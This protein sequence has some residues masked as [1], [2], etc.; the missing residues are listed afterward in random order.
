MRAILSRTQ[1]RS[2]LVKR[3]PQSHKGSFG[4]VLIIA[5][6]RGM[7]GAGVLSA[8]GALRGGAG[9]V[10][11]ATP[12]SLQ[13][14]AARH[15]R[16]EAMTLGLPERS[17]TL[18]PKAAAPLLAFIRRRRVTSIALGPGL[19]R[20]RQA[21][22][23]AVRFFSLLKKEAGVNGLVLD[24]DGFLA[25]SGRPGP[26]KG[27]PPVIVTPHPGELAA[28]LKTARSRVEAAR[29]ETAEKFAK[30]NGVITVLKGHRTVVTDG[31]R[32]FINPTGNPGMA[33]G[34]SGD[35]L[36]GLIPALLLNVKL[37]DQ[38]LK[39]AA[40]GVFVH[41]LAGDLAAKEKT[42][43]AMTAGDIAEKIPAAFKKAL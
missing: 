19:S 21:Q 41:G 15:L 22:A 5:G 25:F 33:R 28:F 9:L 16:P 13:L 6:S 36:S 10:T 14:I 7:I 32:T 11:L 40:A 38:P 37:P 18:V 20:A 24:A 1:I 35:V 30:L 27:G 2:W 31:K 26:W 29:E 12:K 23:F 17:G 4:H 39:A 34:G 8:C 3:P 42:Q 43:I